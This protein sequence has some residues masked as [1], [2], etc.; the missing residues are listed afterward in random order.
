MEKNQDD[1]HLTVCLWSM[2][3]SH[4]FL[5]E[6]NLVKS[7]MLENFILHVYSRFF[8]T[9][10]MFSN[11]HG[12]LIL[13]TCIPSENPS[14][15]TPPSPPS[16]PSNHPPA[17]ALDGLRMCHVSRLH[18]VAAHEGALI[19]HGFPGAS[20]HPVGPGPREYTLW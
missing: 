20:S 11:H 6:L 17:E 4:G 13:G 10:G 12:G 16:P 1:P 8:V 3:F 2:W 5:G 19:G 9:H 14:A 7:S 18:G 15:P